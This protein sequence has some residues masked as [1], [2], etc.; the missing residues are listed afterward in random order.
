[1]AVDLM[2]LVVSGCTQQSVAGGS[3]SA[4]WGDVCSRAQGTVLCKQ[5]GPTTQTCSGTA[6]SNVLK[7][8]AHHAAAGFAQRVHGMV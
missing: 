7:Y 2:R 3:A 1:M 6:S 8:L 4:A 5:S